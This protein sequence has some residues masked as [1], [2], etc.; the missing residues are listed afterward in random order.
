MT[1]RQAVATTPT[2][3]QTTETP[4]SPSF[5][6]PRCRPRPIMWRPT[7]LGWAKHTP[8]SWDQPMRTETED[9]TDTLQPLAQEC[10]DRAKTATNRPSALAPP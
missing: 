8:A 1:T 6:V 4:E 2:Q 9:L 3:G 10:T 7:C 5:H